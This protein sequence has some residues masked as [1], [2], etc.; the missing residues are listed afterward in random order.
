MK[1]KCI[2]LSKHQYNIGKSMLVLHT[3]VYGKS[4]LCL[5][6]W[7]FAKASYSGQPFLPFLSNSFPPRML[8]TLFSF[9][10]KFLDRHSLW[11]RGKQ[12]GLI[13]S[14]KKVN[15][16][17][18]S[19]CPSKPGFVSEKLVFSV[20]QTSPHSLFKTT[21]CVMTG[22]ISYSNVSLL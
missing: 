6:T 1:K 20:L 18:F 9:S 5:G 21:V 13:C 17:M 15:F 22:E 10:I 12:S 3:D 8:Y 2:Y 14:L 11:W 16:L 7:S 4:A 19:V